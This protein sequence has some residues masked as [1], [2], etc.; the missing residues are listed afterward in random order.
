MTALRLITARHLLQLTMTAT[1]QGQNF[2]LFQNLPIFSRGPVFATGV[3][4][5]PLALAKEMQSP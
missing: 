4:C 1:G 5:F 2:V 3:N